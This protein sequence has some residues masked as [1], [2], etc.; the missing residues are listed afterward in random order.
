VRLR[1]RQGKVMKLMALFLLLALSA[2]YCTAFRAKTRRI[3]FRLHNSFNDA[4]PVWSGINAP[5]DQTMVSLA[6]QFPV[7]VL[8]LTN[9]LIQS[10]FL[11][12]IQCFA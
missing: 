1:L 7:L 9:L 10:L 4:G 2:C 8:L 6:F 3:S 12:L 11:P 5:N